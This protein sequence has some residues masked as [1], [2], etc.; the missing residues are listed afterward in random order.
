M[1]INYFVIKRLIGSSK[2][3]YKTS[4]PALSQLDQLLPNGP[5]T[6][7]T[8]G[9]SNTHNNTLHVLQRAPPKGGPVKQCRNT[10]HVLFR[11]E[12]SG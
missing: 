11:V 4:G 8:L 10:F 6:F 3:H 7:S 1:N 2:G 5:R 9:C 12:R